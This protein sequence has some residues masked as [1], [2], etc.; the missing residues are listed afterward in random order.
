MLARPALRM[1]SADVFLGPH[2][3]F[4]NM[5]AKVSKMTTGRPNPFVDPME[6][7]RF[8]GMS[9]QQFRKELA[10]EQTSGH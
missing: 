2:P 8:V 9:H 10:A 6:L 5:A 1:L 4:F 3:E 7:R